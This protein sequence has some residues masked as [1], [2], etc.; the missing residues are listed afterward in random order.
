MV[1]LNGISGGL[2]KILNDFVYC[3]K[4]QV[5]LN[6]QHASWEN[7][8]TGVLQEYFRTIIVFN[9]HLIFIK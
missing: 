4:Q 2:K 1:S 6:E 9:L 3:H 8:N 5:A 7:V